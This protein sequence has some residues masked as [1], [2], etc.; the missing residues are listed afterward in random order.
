[1]FPRPIKV[2]LRVHF[3]LSLP[4]AITSLIIFQWLFNRILHK[5]LF[6]FLIIY[7]P[8]SKPVILIS[9]SMQYNPANIRNVCWNFQSLGRVNSK[10]KEIFYVAPMSLDSSSIEIFVFVSDRFCDFFFFFA[11]CSWKLRWYFC[12]Q[13]S[14]YTYCRQQ[15]QSGRSMSE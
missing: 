2:L 9:I 6:Y 7:I 8:S 1:M 11:S 3:H 13:D 10:T 14:I 4:R 12:N 5:Y 15:W